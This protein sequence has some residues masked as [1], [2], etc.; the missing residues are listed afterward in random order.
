MQIRR[1]EKFNLKTKTYKSKSKKKRK[2]KML[3]ET[4]LVTK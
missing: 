2:R 4:K 3:S 1:T